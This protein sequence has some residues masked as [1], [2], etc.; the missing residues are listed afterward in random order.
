MANWNGIDFFIFLLFFLN[1]ILGLS[2]G[3]TK[4]IISI[5]CLS[6]ALIFTLKFT[7]PI[8]HFLNNSPLI[9]DVL[10]SK[11]VQNFMHTIGAG[12]LTAEMLQQLSYCLAILVCFVGT[13]SVCEAMLGM[14][15]FVEVF[16][17][18]YATLNRKVGAA[19]GATRGYIFSLIFILILV[20]LFKG[21]PLTSSYFVNLFQGSVNKLDQFIQGQ[22]VERYKELY[23]GKDLYNEK[24]VFQVIQ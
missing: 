5:M 23:E 10:T 9:N 12:P 19:L 15:G 22:Q 7:V 18:P 6:V 21:G 16:K 13:F 8:T 3:A 2:R 4:E 24:N 20:H 11:F 17:F 1:V 14:T